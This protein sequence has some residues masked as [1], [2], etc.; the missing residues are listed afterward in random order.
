MPRAGVGR[1]FL[2]QSV[3]VNLGGCGGVG[4]LSFFQDE[5]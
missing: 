5:T 2:L 1:A 3:L 4:R